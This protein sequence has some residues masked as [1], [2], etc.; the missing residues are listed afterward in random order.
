MSMRGQSARPPDDEAGVMV[1][2]AGGRVRKSVFTM[3]AKG[4]AKVRVSADP[5][6]QLVLT[7]GLTPGSVPHRFKAETSEEATLTTNP[8]GI[9][10]RGTSAFP[11]PQTLTPLDCE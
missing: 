7:I 5:A 3:N 8:P 1:W 2:Q 9:P 10:L 4:M 11:A 6:N